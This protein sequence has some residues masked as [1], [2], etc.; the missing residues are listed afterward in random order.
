VFLVTLL[1][2]IFV[3]VLSSGC[4]RGQ[5][6]AEAGTDAAVVHVPSKP[7]Q[8]TRDMSTGSAVA[9]SQVGMRLRP[10][11]PLSGSLVTSELVEFTWSPAVH[12]RLQLARSVAFEPVVFEL[13]GEGTVEARLGAGRWFWRVVSDSGLEASVAWQVSVVPRGTG[14]VRQGVQ[15]GTD[16]NGDGLDASCSF[17]A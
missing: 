3:L 7:D 15:Y 5:P 2:L 1:A 12:G 14:L 13:L 9:R 6:A 17:A 10:R 4:T 16:V 8:K 11:S